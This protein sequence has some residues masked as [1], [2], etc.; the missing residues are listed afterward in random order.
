MLIF[1]TG[2]THRSPCRLQ[3]V[4]SYFE[5]GCREK[6]TLQRPKDIVGG[7][8]FTVLQRNLKELHERQWDVCLRV[9]KES[10]KKVGSTATVSGTVYIQHIPY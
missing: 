1:H 8:E 7:L 2:D 5:K 10:N 4:Y 3:L 6:C 9:L